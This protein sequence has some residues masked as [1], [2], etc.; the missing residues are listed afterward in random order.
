MRDNPLRLLGLVFGTV[1]LVVGLMGF[2]VTGFGNLIGSTGDLAVFQLNPLH[3]IA[4]LVIG[5]L[6]LLSAASADTARAAAQVF[7]TV[8]LVLSILGFLAVGAALNALALNMGDNVLHL[9]SG[10]GALLLSVYLERRRRATPSAP[11][12]FADFR[13]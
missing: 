9:V 2:A 11:E 8:Y 12:R 3:N 5:L 1:Y 10:G 6:W 4:H 7:G 13:N